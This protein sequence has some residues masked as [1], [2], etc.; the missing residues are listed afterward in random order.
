MNAAIIGGYKV[1]LGMDGHIEQRPPV[2][3]G[4]FDAFT[5]GDARDDNQAMRGKQWGQGRINIIDPPEVVSTPLLVAAVLSDANLR[6]L[7]LNG[8]NLGEYVCRGLVSCSGHY[9]HLS[10][11]RLSAWH[12]ALSVPMIN[13]MVNTRA[14]A[15]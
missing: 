10:E 12:I 1:K 7:A 5:A 4:A 8:G 6:Q 9:W 11:Y 2:F 14:Q 3:A 15:A 13:A